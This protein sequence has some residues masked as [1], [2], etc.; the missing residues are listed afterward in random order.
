MLD[1]LLQLVRHIDQAALLL[2]WAILP[3]CATLQPR[4]TFDDV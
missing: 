1:T 2:S 4:A 3:L